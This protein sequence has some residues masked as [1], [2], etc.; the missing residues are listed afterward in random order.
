[1]SDEKSW[2]IGAADNCDFV[3]DVPTVSGE[4]C[5]ITK[6][7]AGY[8][9]TDLQSTNGTYVN[10]TRVQ[11]ST[12]VTP[13][14]EIRMG[15]VTLFP[16]SLVGEKPRQRIVRIGRSSTCDIVFDEPSV[17]LYH[18]QIISKDGQSIIQDLESTNGVAIDSPENKIKTAE[19]SPNSTVYFGTYLVPASEL[20]KAASPWNAFSTSSASLSSLSSPTLSVGKALS[21]PGQLKKIIIGGAI[22]VA[23][24]LL[25]VGLIIQ[26]SQT[27]FVVPP[28]EVP[29]ADLV[30]PYDPTNL[31][32][33]FDP[34]KTNTA[35][36]TTIQQIPEAAV[37]SVIAQIRIK[38]N[39]KTSQQ[40]FR[41]GSAF[42]ISE[43]RLITSGSAGL[44][45]V[46]NRK[47]FPVIQIHSS[48]NNIVYE[49]KNISLL[50][51]YRDAV[52]KGM[53][54]GS[55]AS[56][57]Q[58]KIEAESNRKEPITVQQHQKLAE[59]LVKHREKQFQA[60]ERQ[61]YLDVSLLEIKEKLP[62]LLPLATKPPIHN[63]SLKILG[64]AFPNDDAA[65]FVDRPLKVRKMEGFLFRFVQPDI[66][67][68]PPL[69]RY[70]VKCNGSHL[71][72]HWSGS[73]VLD[74]KNRVIGIYSRPSLPDKPTD[75][76]PEN[77]CDIVSV[78]QIRKLLKQNP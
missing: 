53:T 59:E 13:D 1:M 57:I 56:V 7:Q 37:Y 5:R 50:Q 19:L 73:P 48:L 3:F 21:T 8:L 30:K 25:V 9:L 52:Q 45:L 17:S 33:P 28:E 34:G 16:W 27:K 26:S 42:A 39:G 75:A 11:T 29:P 40:F 77:R 22:A 41:L 44:L 60:N 67:E 12:I 36:K 10:G 2:L 31:I 51:S 76:R 64:I 4:H 65:F 32:D 23:L 69:V 20:I 55:A 38:K 78:D 43:H 63:A 49:V 72:H 47:E 18:A 6:D 74:S 61:T 66:K 46:R 62:V 71:T 70:L 14:D 24:L 68:E 54:A 58:V 35:E 15:A